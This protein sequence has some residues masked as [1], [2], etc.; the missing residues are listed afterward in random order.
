LIDMASPYSQSVRDL[1][2]IRRWAGMWA[3]LVTVQHL[4][5][6][7]QRPPYVVELMKEGGMR[8]SRAND[9]FRSDARRLD[10]SRLGLQINQMLSQLRQRIPPSQ[11]GLGEETTSHVLNL[12]EQLS[13]PWSLLATA[14]KFRRFPSSGK[15]R[16]CIGFEAMHYA[17]TGREF[18][19]ADSAQ[20][21][22]RSQFETLF[23]FR[24]MA[25]PAEQLPIRSHPDF[26]SDEWD[27]LN[28]SANGF[29]IVRSSAGQKLAHSQL[30]ALCPH[31]GER[32]LLAQA[33]W[34]MQ[35]QDGGLLAGL[36]VVPGL[37]EGVAV[38]VATG[39]HGGGEL[40]ERAFL[41]PAVPAIEEEGSLVL[42]V[43]MYQASRLLEVHAEKNTWLIRMKNVLQRGVDFERISFE[44]A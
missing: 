10:I 37:P 29:R 22:S 40:F 39:S 30:L 18:I 31:D 1:N 38:R 23:T 8:P 13:R 6:D 24:Q 7:A 36:S 11:L 32:F 4:Q 27:V 42:P 41:L 20:T 14:R 21:Y 33:C 5:E 35:E 15:A 2:L 25:D 17:V 19:Q 43:G 28:H 16:V 3:P 44:V 12:L 34:L 9:A 26:S